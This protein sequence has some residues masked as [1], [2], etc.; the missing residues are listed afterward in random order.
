[1]DPDDEDSR[2]V[3][4]ADRFA[5]GS[6]TKPLTGASILRLVEQGHFSLDDP[7][8]P[9]VDPVLQ[10]MAAKD[11][12]QSFNSV[13]DLWGERA[14]NIT[15]RQLATMQ[16]PIPDFDTAT[17]GGDDSLRAQL[18]ATPDKDYSPTELM[19][20]PWVGELSD[21]P[22]GYSSTNFMLLGLILAAQAGRD[23]WSDFDQGS[24]LP[25]ALR[26]QVSFADLGAPEDFTTVHGHDRT[27]YNM[28]DNETNDQDVF[29]VDG[30]FAGWT[31]SNLVASPS[32]VAELYWDIYG[33]EPSVAKS[34]SGFMANPATGGSG[35]GGFY[36]FATF[37]LSSHT[38]LNENSTYGQ[39]WGHLGATYGYQSVAMWLPGLQLTM[40]VATNIE[41]DSQAQ[42]ADVVCFAYNA[43]ATRMLGRESQCTFADRGYYSAGCTC[44]PLSE[45][46]VSV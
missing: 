41:T 32:A 7:M 23:T 43:L 19:A 18:Y 30:V 1:V 27:S 34:S 35:H 3:T 21:K 9:L 8:A 10:R 24:V 17:P 38:G 16:S 13:S 28:P 39:A 20:L 46:M 29:A 44:T 36:G 37:Q 6:G 5:W 45:P 4:S 11:P 14:R 25:E 2:S 31:A 40:A 22:V 12:A 33:P 15:V 26:S 42:P